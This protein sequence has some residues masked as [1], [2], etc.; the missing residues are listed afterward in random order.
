MSGSAHTRATEERTPA[1]GHNLGYVGGSL[2]TF[3]LLQ[4]S[5]CR[6][7]PLLLYRRHSTKTSEASEKHTPSCYANNNTAVF[8]QGLCQPCAGCTCTYDADQQHTHTLPA[9]V[10]LPARGAGGRS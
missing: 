10:V 5:P 7:G 3:H 6:P 2:I 8:S 9:S 1:Y 4:Q